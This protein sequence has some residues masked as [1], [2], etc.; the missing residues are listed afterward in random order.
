[1]KLL[2][3]RGWEEYAL[4]D[5]GDGYRLERFG[6]YCLKRP[7]PQ[8]IWQKRLPEVWTKID[9]VFAKRGQDRE[10][11]YNETGIPEKWLMHYGDLSFWAKLTPFKHTG[12]FPEQTVEW[13]WMRGEIAQHER[14][15][16][17]LNL[18]AYKGIASLACAKAGANVTHVDA[19][20]PAITWAREN[21]AASGLRDAPIRWI[22]DDVLKFVAREIR[23]GVYYDGVIMDPPVFGHG[24]DGERWEFSESFATLFSLI[25]QVMSDKPAFILINAYAVSVSHLMLWNMLDDFAKDRGGEVESGELALAESKTGRL[26]S[27]GIY[28]RWSAGK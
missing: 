4:L 19:S 25:R 5:S 18:F 6:Q 27:T 21:Q 8:A 13:D 28:G 26:L 17:I 2:Q 15:L 14:K 16:H 3:T 11:W 10:G 23:R 20:R 22:L 1:M 9:A 12:V 24:P 7:D